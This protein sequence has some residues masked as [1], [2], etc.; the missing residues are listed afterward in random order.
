MNSKKLYSILVAALVVAGLGLFGSVYYANSILSSKSSELVDLRASKQSKEQQEKQ[1]VK[2]KDDIKTY[3]DLNEIAKSVV[4]QDKDQ[5][6]TVGE[7]VELASQSGIRR[8]G[9]ITFPPSTLGGTTKSVKTSKG[10]TQVTPVKG[11]PG[12]YELQITVSQPTTDP[13]SYGSFIN[14]LSKLER[15]RRTAQVSSINV[16][17]DAARSDLVSFTLVLNEYIK[18]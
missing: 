14:F 18:P 10:L 1:L 13:V 6:K 16:Q 11:L 4:P 7:I 5:A 12:V 9:S 15:N 3:S 2:A 8:L 17:P